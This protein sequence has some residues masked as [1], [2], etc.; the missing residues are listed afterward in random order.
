MIRSSAAPSNMCKVA[1]IFL[2]LLAVVASIPVS[3]KPDEIPVHVV[4]AESVPASNEGKAL[5]GEQKEA[6]PETVQTVEAVTKPALIELPQLAEVEVK[7]TKEAPVAVEQEKK[8]EDAPAAVEEVK[9][10]EEVSVAVEEEQ[11]KKTTEDSAPVILIAEVPAPAPEVASPEPEAKSSEESDDLEAGSTPAQKKTSDEPEKDLETQSSV[12][13][14]WSAPVVHAAVA[15]WPVA[16]SYHSGWAAPSYNYY[17]T[18][19]YSH[20]YW[21]AATTYTQPQVYGGWW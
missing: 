20:S 6:V 10:T 19:H 13:G 17:P 11:E 5:A 18:A 8:T 14:G 4:L 1:I 12:W 2:G 7:E 16:T 9:K 3:Y 15:P 21:P